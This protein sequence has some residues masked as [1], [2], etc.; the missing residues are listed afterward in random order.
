MMQNDLSFVAPNENGVRICELAIKEL[1]NLVIEYV[2]LLS[3]IPRFEYNFVVSE[4]ITY[5]LLL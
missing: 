2:E 1:S 4:V 5:L 3:K